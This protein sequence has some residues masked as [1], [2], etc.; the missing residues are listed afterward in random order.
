VIGWDGIEEAVALDAAGSFAGAA[1][2][3]GVSTSHVSRAI[4]R[5]EDIV[6]RQF[7]IARRVG[8]FSPTKAAY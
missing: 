8:S 3:L 1:A 7:S 6:Q 5:L 2:A 4:A